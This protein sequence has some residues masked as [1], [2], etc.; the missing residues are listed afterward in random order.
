MV[1]LAVSALYADVLAIDERALA[2]NPDTGRTGN[3]LA[4]AAL[5]NALATWVI[6]FRRAAAGPD[7]AVLREK[8]LTR[9]DHDLRS[10][11]AAPAVIASLSPAIH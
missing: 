3:G 6:F 9:L 4:T 5:I 10:G 8:V 2:C 1:P 11:G 7:N